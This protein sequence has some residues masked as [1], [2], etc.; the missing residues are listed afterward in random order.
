MRRW[1][2]PLLLIA[3]IAMLGA[4]VKPL[5][6]YWKERNRPVYRTVSISRGEIVATVTATGSV[7]PVLSVEVGTFVSGPIVGLHVDFNA[8]VKKD[9]LLAEIDP[10]LYKANVARDEATLATSIANLDQADAQLKQARN[11]E[12]RANALRAD[13]ENFISDSEM[14]QYKFGRLSFEARLEVAKASIK[15][16]EANL[17]NSR[18]NLNYTQIKS[19][20]DGIVIDRKIEPGQTLAATFQTPV[21]FVIAPDMHEEMHILVSVDESDIGHIKKAKR[22][23]SPVR[24]TVDA[25]PEE[26]FGGDISQIRMSSTATQ[27]VVTYPVIVSAENPE[28]KLMPGMTANITF[29]IEKSKKVQRVPNAALRYYPQKENVR[30]EDHSILDGTDWTESEENSELDSSPSL[31]SDLED[32]KE[33]N[34]RHVWA[35]TAQGLK[36]IEVTTGLSDFKYTELVVGDVKTD[37]LLVTGIK[38]KE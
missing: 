6:D 38:P 1:L 19:P 37:D 10:R 17:E 2:K 11:D 21:L 7:Q 28:L 3:V 16:A 9:D 14:D 32:G 31:F 12:R 33:R 23:L 36:A 13:N 26:I 20:V 22:D 15:Q 30:S 5:Q 4:S 8:E 34:E 35:V 27:G 24:F 25:Y 18:T 29:Q